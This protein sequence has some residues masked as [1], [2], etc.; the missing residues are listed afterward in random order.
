MVSSIKREQQQLSN[1]C[2][3]EPNFLTCPSYYACGLL[4]T[5]LAGVFHRD[6]VST[7]A[8]A[9]LSKVSISSGTQPAVLNTPRALLGQFNA[10]RRFLDWKTPEAFLHG[11]HGTAR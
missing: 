5:C 10:V 4:L 1:A 8:A 3:A 9:A 2:L 6:G 7:A 11:P